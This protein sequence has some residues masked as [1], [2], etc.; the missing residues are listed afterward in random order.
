MEQA[1]I[2]IIVAASTLIAALGGQ[3]IAAVAA[4]KRKK[5]ELYFARKADAYQKL[6]SI[7]GSYAFDPQDDR[8]HDEFVSAVE[9]VYMI[10]SDDV[11]NTLKGKEGLFKNA[12][13][14]RISAN[15]DQRESIRHHDWTKA[16]HHTA[17]VMRE[18]LE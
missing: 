3:L 2:P 11:R 17:E 6:I 9:V 1:V 18:D 15:P 4:H 10:G 7:A 12:H 14:L 13:K 16:F 8:K 5:L